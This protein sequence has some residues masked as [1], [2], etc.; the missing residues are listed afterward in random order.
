MSRPPARTTAAAPAARGTVATR[1]PAPQSTVRA[2]QPQQHATTAK[3]QGIREDMEN[4]NEDYFGTPA[5]TAEASAGHM[6]PSDKAARLI[7][8]TTPSEGNAQFA[9]AVPAVEMPLPDSWGVGPRDGAGTMLDCCDTNLLCMAVN[10]NLAVAGGAD[11]GLTVWDTNTGRKQRTLFA[12]RFGHTEWVTTCAWTPSGQVLSGGMD[13]ALCLWNKTAATC[14]NLTHPV[15][16]HRGGISKVEVNESGIAVSAS[17]DRT[18][19]LWNTGAR[20]GGDAFMTTLSGHKNPVTHFV[21]EHN[22][23]VSGDRKGELM[24]WDVTASQ[25]VC[26][27]P[28][29][30]AGAQVG[31]MGTLMDGDM[32]LVLAGDQAGV[33]AVWDFRAAGGTPVHRAQQ[34]PGGVVAAVQGTRMSCDNFVVTAGADKVMHVLEPRMSYS[35][36]YTWRDHKDF[37]YS[38]EVHGNYVL[39][40]AGNGWLLVHDVDSGSCAYALGAGEN[41]VRCIGASRSKLVCAG[42]DG[43]MMVYDYA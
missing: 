6:P 40:G 38:M 28:G 10:G 25:A 36:L 42:D 37:I 20:R 2:L 33:V 11:H 34:H 43:K 35:P 39:S 23:L 30:T 3:A 15:E 14:E 9:R 41:A 8:A 22:T 31:A 32:N 24:V 19:K 29:L 27:L 4:L 16:S 12:K 26:K 1:A 17:Y 7:S 18:L 21:W 13:S 5:N